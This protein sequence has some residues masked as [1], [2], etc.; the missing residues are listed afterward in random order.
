MFRK[1]LLNSIVLAVL[2]ASTAAYAQYGGMGAPGPGATGS[3]STPTYTQKSYGV[4]KAAMG[5]V[6]GGGVAGGA[7]LVRHFRHRNTMTACV[8]SDGKTL[9]DGKEVYSAR[10]ESLIPNERLVVAGK[11]MKSDTGEPAIEVTQVRKDLGRCEVP[12][13]SAQK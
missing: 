10:G 11:K 12:A 2:G 1:L 3:T 5:A 8:G 13:L 7:L 6:L 4:N 9:S